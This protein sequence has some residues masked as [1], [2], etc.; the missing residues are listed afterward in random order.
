MYYNYYSISLQDPRVWNAYNVIVKVN[1]EMGF[2]LSSQMPALKV[3]VVVVY[4]SGH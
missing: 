3:M 1:P 4:S 2:L